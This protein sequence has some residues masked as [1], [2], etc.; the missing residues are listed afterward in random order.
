MGTTD[1]IAGFPSGIFGSLLTASKLS[2]LNSLF[3]G[4]LAFLSLNTAFF[5]Y[6][7]VMI[8]GFVTRQ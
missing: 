3:S 6:E 5:G 8:L 2:R 1:R 7:G 4:W